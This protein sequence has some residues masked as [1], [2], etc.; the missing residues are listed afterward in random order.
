MKKIFRV[1]IESEIDHKI[2]CSAITN[3]IDDFLYIPEVIDKRKTKITVT[4]IQ[5]EQLPLKFDSVL[6]EEIF[7]ETCRLYKDKTKI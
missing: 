1:E 4:E 5:E 3:L 2:P 6:F 7:D